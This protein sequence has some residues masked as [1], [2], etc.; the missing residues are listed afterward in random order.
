MSE[1]RV[2]TGVPAA[3]ASRIASRTSGWSRA[4]MPMPPLV[5]LQFAQAGG[6]R[7]GAEAVDAVHP[8]LDLAG[9]R[10]AQAGQMAGEQVHERVGPALQDE[11]QAHGRGLGA[12]S[13][14]GR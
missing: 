9:A 4:M 1:T 10:R 12:G 7:L 2:S 3:A 11:V 13:A 8:H 5:A 6:Q 14:S